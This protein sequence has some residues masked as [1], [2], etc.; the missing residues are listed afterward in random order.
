[1]ALSGFIKLDVTL[2]LRYIFC[3]FFSRSSIAALSIEFS[4]ICCG[5]TVRLPIVFISLVMALC[6]PT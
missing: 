6:G 1:M 4:A 2:P 3:K 5:D